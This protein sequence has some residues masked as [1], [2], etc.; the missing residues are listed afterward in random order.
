VGQ[1][2]MY[3][4]NPLLVRNEE[5]GLDPDVGYKATS[6][7]DKKLLVTYK[8]WGSFESTWWEFTCGV[9]RATK[10]RVAKMKAGENDQG[11]TCVEIKKIDDCS[12]TRRNRPIKF[13]QK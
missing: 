1:G 2:Y 6:C 4:P 3:L 8:G 13:V 5:F 10:C 12:T 7:Q 9:E 11:E